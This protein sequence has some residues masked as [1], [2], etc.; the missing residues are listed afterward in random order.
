MG[1]LSL[2]FLMGQ[3][4]KGRRKIKKGM[5]GV[6]RHF[7]T[8]LVIKVN[9]LMTNLLGE[10]FLVK[11]MVVDMKDSLKMKNAKEMVGSYQAIKKS[12]MKG[13]LIMMFRMALGLRY[14]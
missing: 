8:G 2:Y 14:L 12:Y 5:D 3:C 7:R 11:L 9:G 10:E 13:N 4:I 6:N 1:S